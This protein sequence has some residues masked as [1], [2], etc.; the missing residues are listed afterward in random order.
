MDTLPVGQRKL[1]VEQREDGR[2][3]RKVLTTYG[4]DS[5]PVLHRNIFDLDGPNTW[6]FPHHRRI[7][8]PA[9]QRYQEATRRGR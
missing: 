5:R 3:N 9:F 7:S 6:C 1:K 8:L 4:S 2:K